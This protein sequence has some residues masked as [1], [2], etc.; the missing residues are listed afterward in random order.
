MVREAADRGQTALPQLLI[1]ARERGWT[2]DQ[3]WLRRVSNAGGINFNATDSLIRQFGPPRIDRIHRPPD[4]PMQP[5]CPGPQL[6][7]FFGKHIQS[8]VGDDQLNAM[9]GRQL[10]L[11]RQR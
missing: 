9:N 6:H 3:C 1:T 7:R 4:Q 10:V 8:F 11:N 2:G 5:A